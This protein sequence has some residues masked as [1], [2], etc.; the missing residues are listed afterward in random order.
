V[1]SE[2]HIIIDNPPT[3]GSDTLEKAIADID[4]DGILDVVWG[5]GTGRG[6]VGGLV[7]YTA[8]H[9]GDLTQAWAKHIIAPSGNF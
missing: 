5:Y 8:P 9:S 1:P 3:D 4:G 2:S 7:W 6:G